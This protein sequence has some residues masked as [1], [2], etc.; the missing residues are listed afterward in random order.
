[1]LPVL[2]YS[3][4]FP[5]IPFPGIEYPSYYSLSLCGLE[6]LKYVN[7]KYLW[8]INEQPS[9]IAGKVSSIN[10][11]LRREDK[12]RSSKEM[13]LFLEDAFKMKASI[14]FL[15]MVKKKLRLLT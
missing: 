10:I 6:S 1:M 8:F 2:C 15:L 7:V 11:K 5:S 13:F 3:P 4:L 12:G 9:I 14:K